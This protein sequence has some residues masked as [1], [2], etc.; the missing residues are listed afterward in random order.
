MKTYSVALTNVGE[1]LPANVDLGFLA[2]KLNTLQKTFSFEVVASI[3]AELFGAPDLGGQWYYFNR[4]FGVIE[5]HKDFGRYDY[6]VGITH[7]RVTEN[8][9]S[10]DDGNRDYFSMSDLNKISVITLNQNITVYTSPT[11][12]IYQFLA[13]AITGELLSNVA[14]SYLYHNKVHYCLFDECIDRGNVAPVMEASTICSDC[15]HILK[16]KGVS[17]TI[18]NDMRKILDWCRRTTGKSSPFYCAVFHPFTSLIVGAAM[19]WASSAFLKSSQY[20]YVLA[21]V[22]A[23]PTSVYLYYFKKSRRMMPNKT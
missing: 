9:D 11:K 6:F 13:F 2:N 7:V 14:K 22:I 3:P 12:D 18:L 4:L 19:G 17:E 15:Y 10:A 1:R 21:S 5:N 20:L 16:T 23:V 8:E